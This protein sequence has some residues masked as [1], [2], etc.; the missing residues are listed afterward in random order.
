MSQHFKGKH[1]EKSSDAS[2]RWVR[3]EKEAFENPSES[4]LKQDN[5]CTNRFQK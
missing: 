5:N 2:A 3:Q 4:Y 1:E